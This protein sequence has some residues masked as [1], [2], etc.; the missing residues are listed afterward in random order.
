[1]TGE[2]RGSVTRWVDGLKAG[3]AEAI[4]M[5]WERYFADLARLARARLS[6]VSRAA[7]DE[8]DAA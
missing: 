1:M 6:A 4:R 3:D 7:A 2:E 5:L 8:E